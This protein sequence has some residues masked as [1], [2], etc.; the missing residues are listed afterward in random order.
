MQK[1]QTIQIETNK[2]P[3]SAIIWLHGLGASGDDFA[4]I[5]PKLNLPENL[6]VRFIF[7]P[8]TGSSNNNKPRLSNAGLV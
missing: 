7:P 4:P 8:R 5:I 6:A 1:L 2:E 3:D